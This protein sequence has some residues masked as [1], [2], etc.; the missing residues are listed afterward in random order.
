MDTWVLAAHWEEEEIPKVLL[1]HLV[2]PERLARMGRPHME[3]QRQVFA[4]YALLR[5]GAARLLNCT[6]L[7]ELSYG[8]RGKPRFAAYPQLQFSL[9]H[10]EGAALCA[11]SG[12]A[13]GVDV[14]RIR[15][16]PAHRARRLCLSETPEEFYA[17]WVERESRVKCRG[18]SALSCR[19][20]V[21]EEAGEHYRALDLGQEWAAGLC[22]L[23]CAQV[24]RENLCLRQLLETE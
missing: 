7:P 15:P 17:G 16:V 22:T 21:A 14:E 10:T 6:T 1:T 19:K 24:H 4:A 20:P 13:V 5:R 11:L 2:P 18:G 9:S 3:E 12:R 23:S 8:A